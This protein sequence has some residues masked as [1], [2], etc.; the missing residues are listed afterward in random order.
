MKNINIFILIFIT[1]INTS[2]GHMRC[3]GSCYFEPRNTIE[4]CTPTATGVWPPIICNPNI[5]GIIPYGCKSDRTLNSPIKPSSKL[6]CPI[7][8]KTTTDESQCV[9]KGSGYVGCISHEPFCLSGC[10]FDFKTNKCQ[11]FGNATCET[12]ISWNYHCPH[13]CAYNF[14]KQ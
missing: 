11:P 12:Q 4:Q 10:Y 14:D 1:L 9:S 3:S 8:C 7:D 2:H 5:N 13:G 6:L